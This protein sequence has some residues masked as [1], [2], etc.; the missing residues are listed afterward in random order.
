MYNAS[1]QIFV[2]DAKESANELPS[3]EATRLRVFG[4]LQAFGQVLN[5]GAF[6]TGMGVD[7]TVSVDCRTAS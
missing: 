7:G 5:S 6:D 1:A 2:G 4:Y 3:H